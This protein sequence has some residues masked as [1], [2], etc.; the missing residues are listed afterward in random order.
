MAQSQI[1]LYIHQRH[2]VPDHGTQYED[3]PSS[4]HGGMYKDR[5]TD[6]LT[7]ELDLYYIP[8]FHLR[9][10]ENNIINQLFFYLQNVWNRPQL[11][12]F[13]MKQN[14]ILCASV[15]H[16]TWSSTKYEENPSNCHGRMCKDRWMGWQTHLYIPQFCDCWARNNYTPAPLNRLSNIWNS[17]LT[18]LQIIFS[19]FCTCIAIFFIFQ[20]H[21]S[22][23]LTVT[24]MNASLVFP[25]LLVGFNWRYLSGL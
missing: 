16:C 13:G 19:L 22:V 14:A 18:N 23:Y 2:M 5:Q 17:A 8:W 25:S 20:M 21:T 15:A 24:P 7:E 11:I 10:A 3:N 12:I 1:I 4:H 9:R 6:G